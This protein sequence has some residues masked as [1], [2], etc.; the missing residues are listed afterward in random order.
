MRDR[1]VPQVI[2]AEVEEGLADQ[3]TRSYQG[4]PSYVKIVAHYYLREF[5]YLLEQEKEMLLLSKQLFP[6]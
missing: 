4:F 5:E 2:S 3:G 1:S 6:F